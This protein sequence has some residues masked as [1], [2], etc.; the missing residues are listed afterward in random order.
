MYGI[1]LKLPVPYPASQSIV[2][3]RISLLG[4]REGWGYD[5]IRVAYRNWLIAGKETGSEPNISDSL[6]E[7]GKDPNRVLPSQTDPK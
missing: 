2:A 3:N 4:R 6:L 7:I 5:F 1:P